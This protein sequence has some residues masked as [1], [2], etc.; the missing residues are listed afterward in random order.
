MSRRR[1]VIPALLALL[2]L[3]GLA[4]GSAFAACPHE[5]PVRRQCCTSGAPAGQHVCTC[6]GV[7]CGQHAHQTTAASGCA[8]SHTP[9]PSEQPAE[10]ASTAAPRA[11]P[12]VSTAA[13]CVTPPATGGAPALNLPR[14]QLTAAPPPLFLTDCAFLI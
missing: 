7:E 4:V 11:T 1:N 6:G 5:T 10:A 12:L 14:E 8:C 3:P 13:T 2:A 9:P